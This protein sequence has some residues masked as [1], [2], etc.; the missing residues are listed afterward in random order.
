LRPRWR[1]T[2]ERTN[3]EH[4]RFSSCVETRNDEPSSMR[5]SRERERPVIRRRTASIA[6]PSLT[7]AAPAAR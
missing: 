1:T 5:P 7:A 3:S 4:D 6:A 2:G